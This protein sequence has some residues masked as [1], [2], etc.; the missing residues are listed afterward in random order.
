MLSSQNLGR[1][2]GPFLYKSAVLYL[3]EGPENYP[4]TLYGGLLMQ[5]V[6]P[7]NS[8]NEGDAEYSF[9]SLSCAGAAEVESDGLRGFCSYVTRSCRNNY[10]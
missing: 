2:E 5:A 8:W 3:K 10:A 6:Q 7:S 4:Y 9:S 1:F